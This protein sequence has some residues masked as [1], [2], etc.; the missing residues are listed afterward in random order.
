M[1]PHILVGR[2]FLNLSLLFCGTAALL[3]SGCMSYKLMIDA[4]PG[5]CAGLLVSRVSDEDH[6]AVEERAKTSEYDTEAYAQV[7]ENEFQT[8]AQNPLSTFG[9]DV[10]TASYSN[11]RR[12]LTTEN[13]LPPK[14]AVRIE[15]LV[16]Y[17]PYRYAPPRM[18][19]P[20]PPT[21]R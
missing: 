1:P 13:R 17:F 16:N 21:S 5:S 8:V 10:D 18:T 7:H 2:R 9:A 4:P 20:S 3:L 6:S 14:D 19:C 15:E 12:F 11:V